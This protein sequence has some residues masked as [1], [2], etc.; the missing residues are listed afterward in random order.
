MDNVKKIIIAK[1]DKVI[2]L[3]TFTTKSSIFWDITS[4]SPLKVNRYYRL[5]CR[6]HVQG[7]RII[8]AAN[9]RKAGSVSYMLHAG[10]LVL[11]RLRRHVPL[12]QWFTFDG[13]HNVKSQDTEL[14][15]TTAIWAS[16][17]KTTFITSQISQFN[18][19]SD[20]FPQTQC[21]E[22]LPQERHDNICCT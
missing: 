15:I 19:Q 9:Q 20:Y 16:N 12:E 17:H 11:L 18:S 3:R 22:L 2:L 10:C 7:R 5:T 14:F 13:Q 4:C 8:K 1:N 6:L 21:T